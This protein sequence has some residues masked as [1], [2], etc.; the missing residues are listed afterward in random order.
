MA[1]VKFFQNA[2]EANLKYRTPQITAST[3]DRAV[4]TQFLSNFPMP[5]DT[6]EEFTPI[7]FHIKIPD[8][9][10]F[11]AQVNYFE[12]LSAFGG[13]S[14]YVFVAYSTFMATNVHIPAVPSVGDPVVINIDAMPDNLPH[15]DDDLPLAF[16]H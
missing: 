16:W 14:E 7:I 9:P 11:C 10:L 13:E 2:S 12:D 5:N 3:K 1:E 15:E 6:P 4:A 8:G